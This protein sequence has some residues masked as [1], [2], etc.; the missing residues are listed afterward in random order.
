MSSEPKQLSD[1]LGEPGLEAKL[2]ALG[3]AVAQ[4]AAV[5]QAT[6]EQNGG[7]A[8][9]R[10]EG[11][12]ERAA[13]TQARNQGK[14]LN[15]SSGQAVELGSP[16]PALTQQIDLF[17]ATGRAA[18]PKDELATM[19]HP[20]YAIEDGDQRIMTYEHNGV[21][22]EV[23]PSVKGRATIHDKDIVLTCVSKV[24]DAV[25]RGE[26]VSR[27]VSIKAHDVLT[28]T[29]RSTSG[30]GYE[31]LEQAL[32]RLAGTRIKTSIATGKPARRRTKGFGLIDA[33]ETITRGPN[34]RLE[35]LRITLSEFT[36]DAAMALEV[37]SIDQDYFKLRKATEKRLYELARKHCG[38]QGRWKVGLELLQKKVGSRQPLFKFRAAVRS[39]GEE[40]S[41][42][43]YHLVF[44]HTDDSVVFYGRSA[45]GLAAMESD[46]VTLPKP[47]AEG[48]RRKSVRRPT[49]KGI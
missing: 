11:P 5:R 48:S 44:L 16:A 17:I 6:L 9:K 47:K 20:V 30:R 35:E 23:T 49:T 45:A 2:E 24:V 36:F 34:N 8:P 14:A 13:Q 39:I 27:T 41:L 1:L 28:F 21:T 3:K 19:E 25:N 40:G 18:A 15:G 10:Q 33:W 26:P 37:L 7:R 43:G 12:A 42:P 38:D 31:L 4:D 22:L 46:L 32:E 29:N